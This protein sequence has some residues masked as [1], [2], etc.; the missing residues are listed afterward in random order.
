MFTE[1]IADTLIGM[2]AAALGLVCIV[3]GIVMIRW[4]LR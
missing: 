2:A 4:A 3:G 1:V